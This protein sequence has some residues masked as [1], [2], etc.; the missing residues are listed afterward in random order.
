[1]TST[2]EKMAKNQ[3]RPDSEAIMADQ[4]V[5]NVADWTESNIDDE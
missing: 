5:A 4:E 3:E 1:M 2:G